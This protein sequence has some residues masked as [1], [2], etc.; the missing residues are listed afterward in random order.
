VVFIEVGMTFKQ[1]DPRFKIKILKPGD[2]DWYIKSGL[3]VTPRAGFE[4]TERCPQEYQKLL[5]ECWGNGWIKP[6]AYMKESEYIW[7][8]L[9]E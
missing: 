3:T 6:I 7:E 9:S 4:I 8:K 5:M 1:V 2:I